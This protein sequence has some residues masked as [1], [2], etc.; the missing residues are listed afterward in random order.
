MAGE[1]G[2]YSTMSE[3]E[4][5]GFLGLT[6]PTTCLS[7][8]LATIPTATGRQLLVSGWWGMV[9]HPNYLGDL[10]MALA[11]SLPCGEWLGLVQGGAIC[12]WG[13]DG[14][15]TTGYPVWVWRQVHYSGGSSRGTGDGLDVAEQ[16]SVP[17]S[18][19]WHLAAD[20]GLFT[21]ES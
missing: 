12:V 1:L 21:I 17:A 6:Y 19:P 3:V 7:P 16:T 2:V 8:D 11:W 4:R 18:P 14:L 9:R 5:L 20:A 15:V 13:R 10:I